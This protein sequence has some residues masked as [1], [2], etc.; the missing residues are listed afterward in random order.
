MR[1][2]YIERGDCRELIKALPD[3]SVDVVFTSPPYNRIRNDTYE[4]YDDTLADYQGLLEEITRESL[5]V[6]RDKVIVNVQQNHFN[7]HEIYGWLGHF[8]Q[9]VSGGVVWIKNNPQPGNN[10]HADDNTR[11]ITNG[12]EQFF[13]FTDTGKEFRAYGKDPTTNYITSN[14]NT[15]YIE[16]HG[17]VMKK[18]ICE[19]FIRKFT[20]EGDIV[21]DPFMGSGTTAVCCTELGRHYIGFEISPEYC[22][23]AQKRVAEETRQISWKV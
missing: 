9:K 8:A 3:K 19:W 10:Y 20:K 15:D 13:V 18:S 17:A 1:V 5:R 16:G 12:Y 2:D 21:L 4:L 22:E 7:K 11:S 23:I 14:V 6:A